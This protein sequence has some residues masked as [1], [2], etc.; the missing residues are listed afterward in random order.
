MST[1]RQLMLALISIGKTV[2][3]VLQLFGSLPILL[4]I[5]FCV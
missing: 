5:L 3:G 4:K 2:N 1:T